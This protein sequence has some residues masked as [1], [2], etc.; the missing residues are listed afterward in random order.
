MSLLFV[1]HKKCSPL[2]FISIIRIAK[3]CKCKKHFPK[4][5]FCRNKQSIDISL[6]CVR[7]RR[8]IS[9]QFLLIKSVNLSQNLWEIFLLCCLQVLNK[10]KVC[11]S[12]SSEMFFTSQKVLLFQSC[13]YVWF[14]YLH[15]YKNS[16]SFCLSQHRHTQIFTCTHP[17]WRGKLIQISCTTTFLGFF[18][19]RRAC[20]G[21][22]TIETS[23][24]CNARSVGTCSNAT[25]YVFWD[26]FHPSEAANQVLASALLEQGISLVS[27]TVHHIPLYSWNNPLVSTSIVYLYIITVAMRNL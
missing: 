25:Q 5:I 15:L 2:T 21:T 4:N 18:E 1:D 22:G 12:I 3:K 9:N 7:V 20:C 11:E 23:M 6:F 24:L 26:G 27:W 13:I 8:G 14:I 10:S 16:L 19:S 17:K